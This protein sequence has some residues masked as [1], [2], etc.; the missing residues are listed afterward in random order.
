MTLG[1][2]SLTEQFLWPPSQE[3]LRNLRSFTGAVEAR[4]ADLDILKTGLEATIT[5]TREVALGR[6]NAVLTP[7]IT[8]TRT[9]VEELAALAN[10]TVQQINTGLLNFDSDTTQALAALAASAAA[11]LASLD[12]DAQALFTSLEAQGDAQVASV[13][14]QIATAL[15]ALNTSVGNLQAQVDVILSGGLSADNV[16]ESATRAFV[17]PASQ[18]IIDRSQGLSLFLAMTF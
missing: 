17:T 4:L 12:A 16:V 10:V 5:V 13:N 8:E 11:R 14:A 15:A 2:K 18:S 7:I 6:I 1:S 3:V 9:E